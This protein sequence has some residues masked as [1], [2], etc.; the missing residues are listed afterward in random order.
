M[1]PTLQHMFSLHSERQ[2]YRQPLTS[3]AKEDRSWLNVAITD[4]SFDVC[5]EVMAKD[6][7]LTF[8]EE[9]CQSIKYPLM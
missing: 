6:H 8:L 7:F 5:F 1:I 2:I 3:T 9:N 4:F